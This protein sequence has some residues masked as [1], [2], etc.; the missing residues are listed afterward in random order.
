MCEEGAL[1]ADWANMQNLVVMD[2][3]NNDLTGA[4]WLLWYTTMP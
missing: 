2:L 3:S 1:P 4:H